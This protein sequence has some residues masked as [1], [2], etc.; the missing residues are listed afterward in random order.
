[1]ASLTLR[2]QFG[3]IS[4]AAI[5]PFAVAEMSDSAQVKLAAL[6]KTNDA[7][8]AAR[9]RHNRAVIGQREAQAEQ[10]AAHEAHRIASDPFPFH[11]PNVENFGTQREYDAALAEARQMHDSRVR[12]YR[13]R[14]A[15]KSAI[16]AFNLSNH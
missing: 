12:E 5:D 14:E 8:V 15:H 6:I 4:L 7:L 3:Q 9:E 13:A 10:V 11:A 1:M 2:D 16:S